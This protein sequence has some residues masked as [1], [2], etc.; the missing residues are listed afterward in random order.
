MIIL[1]FYLLRFSIYLMGCIN[2]DRTLGLAVKP[3]FWKVEI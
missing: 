2:D 3:N 1:G